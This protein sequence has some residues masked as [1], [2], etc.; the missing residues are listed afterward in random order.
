MAKKD[1]SGLMS[2]AGIMRYFEAEESAIKLDPLFVIIG[3]VV[4]GAVVWGLNLY[5]GRLW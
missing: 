1:T 5:F 3:A 2:S 4:F